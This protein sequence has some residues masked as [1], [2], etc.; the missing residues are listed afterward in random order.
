M[1]QWSHLYY[2][3]QSY[4]YMLLQGMYDQKSGGWSD[5]FCII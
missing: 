5:Y 2:G 1:L 4:T 3:V